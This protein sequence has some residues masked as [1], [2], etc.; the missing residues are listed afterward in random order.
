[1][2]DRKPD[3]WLRELAGLLGTVYLL[4]LVICLIAVVLLL[5]LIAL[6]SC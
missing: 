4:P 1:M 3:H 5:L 2:S 6:R